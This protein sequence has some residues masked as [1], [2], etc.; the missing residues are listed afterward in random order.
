MNTGQT[1]NKSRIARALFLCAGIACADA[2]RAP[3]V[4]RSLRAR[5]STC[6]SGPNETI[7][8][9]IQPSTKLE[10]TSCYDNQFQCARFSVPLD[11]NDQSAGTAAIALMKVPSAY[12]S[13][14]AEY[15]GPLIIGPGG[16]GSSGVDVIQ[17]SGALIQSIVGTEYDIVSFDPRGV[18]RTTPL[19][20]FFPSSA[21]RITW[22]LGNGPIINATPNALALTY[23]RAQVLGD[24]AQKN[25]GN[26][27]QYV[28]TALDATDLLG[29]VKAHGRDKI[30]YMGF[31]WGSILGMTYAAMFPNNIE[32]LLVDGIV[33]PDDYF[34]A[35]WADNLADT[36]KVLETFF[37]S[38]VSA[39]P[40]ACAFYA[41]SPD[42]IV[43]RLDALYASIKRQPVPVFSPSQYG[44]VDYSM[45]RQV[46]MSS[47][48]SPY[49]SFPALAQ[50]LAALEKGDGGPM[51]QMGASGEQL[52]CD[53]PGNN[54]AISGVLGLEAQDAISC[55][56]G[57]PVED[58][59]DQLQA[60]YEETA[61]KYSSFADVWVSHRV[62]CAGWKV[63]PKF[64]FAGPFAANTSFPLLFVSNILDPVAPLRNAVKMAQRYSNASV[65][66]QNGVGHT[67]NT[68]TSACTY[69]YMRS[70]IRDGILPPNGTI[71]EVESKLFAQNQTAA[72]IR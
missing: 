17:E 3:F 66:I 18:S 25:N 55:T 62:R 39:G 60:F 72:R 37:T 7:W 24:I 14:S 9:T 16:P 28:T 27:T 71:C 29:I 49:D 70:Y 59:L 58:G 35:L 13:T 56:D 36:D 53:C 64:R 57:T 61:K 42:Q 51:L 45:L 52:Q 20:S 31:S 6:A 50:A 5:D 40:S 32:R 63:R 46:I 23:A 41:A 26:V 30:Q 22:D 65:L 54:D 4:S 44:T 10:W 47:L 19:I 69:G 15:R 21:E 12:N 43:A 38:C 1:R 8:S 67:T 68:A 48:T 2:R 11:Y 34:A 33:D